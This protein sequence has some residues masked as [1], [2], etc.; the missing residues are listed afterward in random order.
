MSR[1]TKNVL[2]CRAD[3]VLSSSTLHH[4]T[5]TRGSILFLLFA[6]TAVLGARKKKQPEAMCLHS[7]NGRRQTR[8]LV[9]KCQHVCE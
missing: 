2:D 6:N 4:R 9:G 7:G 5:F 8:P 1:E 3:R